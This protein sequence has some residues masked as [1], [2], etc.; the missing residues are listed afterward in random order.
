MEGNRPLHAAAARVA[1]QSA[2]GGWGSRQQIADAST[3]VCGGYEIDARHLAKLERDG[4]GTVRFAVAGN[5]EEQSCMN[6][7]VFPFLVSSI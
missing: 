2:P 6:H 1:S 7:A 5:L 3:S 4:I